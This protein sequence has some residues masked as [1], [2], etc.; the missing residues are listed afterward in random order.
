M[1]VNL[2]E[3]RDMAVCSLSGFAKAPPPASPALLCRHRE[4]GWLQRSLMLWAL[5]N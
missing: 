1:Q 5:F 2:V 3:Y 4:R